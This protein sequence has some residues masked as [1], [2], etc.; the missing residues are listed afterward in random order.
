MLL[1]IVYVRLPYGQ[2][3]NFYQYWYGT[4]IYPLPRGHLYRQDIVRNSILFSFHIHN[5]TPALHVLLTFYSLAFSSFLWVWGVHLYLI[6]PYQLNDVIVIGLGIR[7]LN[8]W[9][10]LISVGRTCYLSFIMQVQDKIQPVSLQF[11]WL[12]CM[13]AMCLQYRYQPGTYWSALTNLSFQVSF[14]S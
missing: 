10:E 8:F 2:Q 14:R 12:A 13:P 1:S 6:L 7:S 5:N 9:C 4:S 3:N 11:P